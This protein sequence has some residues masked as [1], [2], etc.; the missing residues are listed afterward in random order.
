MSTSEFD[1]YVP[2]EF[3]GPRKKRRGGR[4][5]SRDGAGERAAARRTDWLTGRGRGRGE[6][7]VVPEPEFTSYYGHGVVKPV[8]WNH[9]IPAYLFL[10]GVAAGSG[11]LA[12]G[13]LATGNDP[14]RRSAR[15]TAM[16]GAGLS[17]VAL[18]AD[19]G[20]P[21]RFLNMMRTFKVTSP[22]SMGTWIFSGFSA[23]AGLSTACEL[24][25]VLEERDLSALLGAPAAAE[26]EAV[27]DDLRPVLRPV[28]AVA[29][30]GLAVSAAPLAAYT[31]VLLSD[32]ATPLWFESRRH[33]PFVFVSSAALASGGVQMALVPVGAA[34]PARRLAL[35]GVVGDLVAVHRLEEHLE[36]EGVLGPLHSGNPGRMMRAAKALVVAGGVGALL[37]RRS[38]TAGVLGGVALAAA[39]ALTRFAVVEGGQESARDPRWTVEPQRRRLEERRAGGPVGDSI[40]T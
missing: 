27:L 13:A 24:V 36:A 18:I 29:A 8:P 19:L 17:G 31:A 2:P 39:S 33:L 7:P 5:L 9:E 26:L 25:R 28:D 35:L 4:D 14:L 34:A 3:T 32:T 23:F 16:V 22:M 15:F 1:S 6:Q 37:A 12:A 20:R 10:G 38:R 40:T 30:A 11:L 21:E